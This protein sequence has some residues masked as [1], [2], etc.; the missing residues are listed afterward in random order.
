MLLFD[1]TAV[2]VMMGSHQA[3]FLPEF[4][5][6]GHPLSKRLLIC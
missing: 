4:H 2:G 6:I 5:G 3:L 1:I